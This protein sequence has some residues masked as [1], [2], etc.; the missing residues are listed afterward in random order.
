MKKKP[1]G[2]TGG[3]E[4]DAPFEDPEDAVGFGSRRLL[5]RLPTKTY[6][7]AGN[8]RPAHESRRRPAQ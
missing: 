1:H 4:E 2:A 6:C 8:Q 7:T 3:R 5:Q